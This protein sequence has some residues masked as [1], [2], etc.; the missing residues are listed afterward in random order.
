M[1]MHKHYPGHTHLCADWYLT[2]RL[3]QTALRPELFRH[4]ASG[5]TNDSAF[6]KDLFQH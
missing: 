2:S 6:V 1:V 5:L 3:A 4:W